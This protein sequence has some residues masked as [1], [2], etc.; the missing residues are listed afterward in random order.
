VLYW[1][2]VRA[3]AIILAAG[4]AGCGARGGAS[5]STVSVASSCEEFDIDGLEVSFD[6]PKNGRQV[7][8]VSPRGAIPR[9]TD[10]EWSVEGEDVEVLRH[11]RS[12]SGLEAKLKL[13]GL[14][15]GRN[16]VLTVSVSGRCGDALVIF[17]EHLDLCV[18]EDGFE[19]MAYED[20][21]CQE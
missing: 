5:G 17:R 19:L 11:S 18:K 4:L 2:N 12:G 7:V 6:D 3:I 20:A 10:L 16:V 21:G 15:P 13:D 14:D 1:Q 9:G 8:V